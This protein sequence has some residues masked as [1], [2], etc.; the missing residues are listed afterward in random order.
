MDIRV[1]F[2]IFVVM[3]WLAC[4]G[5]NPFS[6]ITRSLFAY[7]GHNES[8]IHCCHLQTTV[9]L[10]RINSWSSRAEK[11]QRSARAWG[12]LF[13]PLQTADYGSI[14]VLRRWVFPNEAVEI[15]LCDACCFDCVLCVYDLIVSHCVPCYSLTGG[16]FRLLT[17]FSL[18]VG[19]IALLYLL[20]HFLSE[21]ITLWNLKYILCFYV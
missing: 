3:L 11:E 17:S 8:L 10:R 20:H 18:T 6:F 16:V 5:A 7:T 12:F 19:D 21:R 1:L 14:H 13:V 9:V 4:M 15:G 2:C